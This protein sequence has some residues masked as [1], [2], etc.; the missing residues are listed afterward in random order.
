MQNVED[1]L[2]GDQV[3]IGTYNKDIRKNALHHLWNLSDL[4]IKCRQL[5]VATYGTDVIAAAGT[6]MDTSY[7]TNVDRIHHP[8]KYSKKKKAHDRMSSS[9]PASTHVKCTTCSSSHCKGGQACAAYKQKCFACGDHGHFRDAKACQKSKFSKRSS[10]THHIHD[11]DDSATESSSSEESASTTSVEKWTKSVAHLEAND[12]IKAC[13][14]VGHIRR[15]HYHRIHKVQPRYQVT[16]MIKE[17][18]VQ[19]FADISV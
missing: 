4:T 17:S 8:G 18:P 9:A 6:T 15:C 3:I 5:E 10:A 7:G 19:V 14:Y 12:K 16:V 1:T 13:K 11:S 2:I